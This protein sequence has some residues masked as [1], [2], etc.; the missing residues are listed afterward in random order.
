M[1]TQAGAPFYTVND[2]DRPLAVMGTQLTCQTY[3]FWDSIQRDD[4][5]DSDLSLAAIAADLGVTE[6]WADGNL[7]ALVTLRKLPLLRALQ[8][9]LFHLDF[10]RLRAIDRELAIAAEQMYPEIEDLLTEYLTPTRAHQE[11]PSAYEIGKKIKDILNELDEEISTKKKSTQ[12]NPE[13]ST[14]IHADGTGELSAKYSA[15]I[16]AEV[17]QLI[18]KQADTRGVSQ[19]QALLD[20][21]RSS[22]EVKVILN[23]YSPEGIPNAPVFVPG[24]GWLDQQASECLRRRAAVVRNVNKYREDAGRSYV[25]SPGLRAFL[26]GRDGTCRYPGCKVPATRC[27]VDHCVDYE[28]GGP[29]AAANCA[30]WCQHHHN[31]KTDGVFTYALDPE[32]AEVTITF[33]NGTV[34][35]TMPAGPISPAGAHWVQQVGKRRERRRNR[36]REDA[37]RQKRREEA[38]E[39]PARDR[40]KPRSDPGGGRDRAGPEPAPGSPPWEAM[41]DDDPPF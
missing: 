36:A 31:M 30:M 6:S 8:E 29:T 26:I 24:V 12:D 23:V 10:Y 13:A 25:A 14:R 28:D 37:K 21:I 16:I 34:V 2:P 33:L 22:N 32:T 20:L 5:E 19:A 41:A 15:E 39:N 11:L 38:A 35:S 9:S 7:E 18:R 1:G 17:G 27:Q 4:D 3:K 40:P